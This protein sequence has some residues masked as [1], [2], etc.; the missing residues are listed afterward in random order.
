MSLT[1]SRETRFLGIWPGKFPANQASIIADSFALPLAVR[2]AVGLLERA[3]AL[4]VWEGG[5]SSR[6]TLPLLRMQR[7]GEVGL[8]GEDSVESGGRSLRGG[9]SG[10]SL[11]GG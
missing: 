2:D 1:A 6:D 5:P 7:D 11:S 9:W 4:R 8:R 10:R 3:Q